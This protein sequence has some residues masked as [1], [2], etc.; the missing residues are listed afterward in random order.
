MSVEFAGGGTQASFDGCESPLDLVKAPDQGIVG[1]LVA[2][3]GEAA[4]AGGDFGYDRCQRGKL[5]SVGVHGRSLARNGT[6]GADEA[7]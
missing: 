4:D 7:R 6:G 3:F 1:V 5:S 2:A